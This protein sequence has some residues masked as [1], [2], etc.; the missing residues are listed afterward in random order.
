VDGGEMAAREAVL[1]RELR[2]KSGLIARTGGDRKSKG[3]SRFSSGMTK[4][5]IAQSGRVVAA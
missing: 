4:R 1:R 2:L 5:K 3:K